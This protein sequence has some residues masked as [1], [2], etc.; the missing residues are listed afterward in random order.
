[1]SHQLQAIIALYSTGS[2]F[3]SQ[4]DLKDLVEKANKE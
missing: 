4:D 1:M 2:R 3:I